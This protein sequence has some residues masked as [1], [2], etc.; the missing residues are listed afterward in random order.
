MA[1]QRVGRLYARMA[2]DLAV[3]AARLGMAG[4]GRLGDEIDLALDAASQVI[5]AE[6]EAAGLRGWRMAA[7]AIAAAMPREWMGIFLGLAAAKAVPESIREADGK[8]WS[9]D[10][11]LA[12]VRDWQSGSGSVDRDEAMRIIQELLLP[13]PSA[14]DV[15]RWLTEAPP[16]GKAWDERLARWESPARG[17]IL[18]ELTT[19]LSSGE[20]V[21]QLRKR[22]RPFADGVAWKAQRIARTEANRAAERANMATIDGLGDLVDGVQIVAV[23]DEWTRPEHAA[24]NGRVYRKGRDGRYRNEGGSPL[25]DLPDAPNCRCM[26]IP[27]M[28]LPPGFEKDPVLRAA[29]KTAA[30]EMIPD[31]ASYVD[32]WRQAS[33]KERM[34]AVGAKRFQAVR[35]RLGGRAPEWTDFIDTEGRLL[36]I[37]EVRG[38]TEAERIDRTK[39][40][41]AMLDQR[42][43]QYREIASRGFIPPSRFL[44]NQDRIALSGRAAET[45]REVSPE[46]FAA[47][48]SKLPPRFA[49]FVTSY[50][51]EQ[52]REMGGQVILSRSGKSGCV[53]KPDG[54]IISVF[55]LPGA[56]E[57]WG[58]IQEAIRRGG[59][60]LDCF[61]GRLPTIYGRHGFKQ[62][63][64]LPWN[65]KDAPPGWKSSDQ[66]DIVFMELP[67]E[68]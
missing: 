62:I 47:A 17:A 54:D 55:S 3:A 5:G 27:V 66:P 65:E 64:R 50:T 61:D 19:G 14:E 36:P 67:P 60:K 6:L 23:M 33:D 63:S 39:R 12:A 9:I 10:D 43:V 48:I 41:A 68:L 2:G 44:P 18:A 56:H 4:L 51:A 58:T 52:Y 38:E 7:A 25:P 40:V 32:W 46:R 16:G 11:L 37:G 28:S 31:P 8:P 1:A 30:G 53:V 57:G 24:R 59:R 35:D 13:A 42:R 20:N 45:H 29:F 22:I 15:R 21:D 26:T 34:R 49:V